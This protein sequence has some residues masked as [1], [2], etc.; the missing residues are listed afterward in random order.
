VHAR[1]QAPQWAVLVWRSTQEVPHSV[2]PAGHWQTPATQVCVAG[3]IVPAPQEGPPGHTLASVVPH[4]TDESA[5][6]GQRGAHSHTKVTGLHAWPLGQSVPRPVQVAPGQELGM[7]WPHVTEV[8]A[9]QL[10]THSHI[11]VAVLQ[12]RPVGQRVPAP[13]QVRTPHVSVSG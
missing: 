10:G 6:A 5:V 13:G 11:R 8:A 12:R 7:S 9:G 2:V 1:P 3:H 4:A